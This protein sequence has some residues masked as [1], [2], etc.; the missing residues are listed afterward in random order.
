[1]GS[2]TRIVGRDVFVGFDGADH[3]HHVE[4]VRWEKIKHVW[5][6]GRGQIEKQ[7][8]GAIEQLPLALAWAITIHKAQGMTLDDIRIDFGGGAF[9]SGQAYVALSRVRTVEGLSLTRPLRLADIS[10]DPQLRQFFPHSG[11]V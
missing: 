1:M 3:Q 5:N 2:V 11:V 4:P 6:A 9:A 10:V 7:V 8:I